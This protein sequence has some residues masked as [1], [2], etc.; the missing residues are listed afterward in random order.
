MNTKRA[1]KSCEGDIG[2]QSNRAE[3]VWRHSV[4]GHAHLLALPHL[5][6]VQS[7]K[8]LLSCGRTSPQTLGDTRGLYPQQTV[9]NTIAL[10]CGRMRRR[11]MACLEHYMIAMLLNRCPDLRI[12][13]GIVH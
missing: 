13:A 7:R 6:C 3:G 2:K 8:A 9:H 4:A 1:D 5:S 11:K 12:G 10:T